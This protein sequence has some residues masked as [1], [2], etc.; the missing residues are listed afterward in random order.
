MTL[1]MALS[2]TAQTTYVLEACIA[3]HPEDKTFRALAEERL[4]P[5][6][7]K[8]E[9]PLPAE[10]GALLVSVADRKDCLNPGE[11]DHRSR[12]D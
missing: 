4:A 9:Q 2:V 7:L 10:C 11:K 5:L 12:E 1:A 6:T 8:P 3:D